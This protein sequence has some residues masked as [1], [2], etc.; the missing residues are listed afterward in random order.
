[1]PSQNSASVPIAQAIQCLRQE[2]SQ[3][4]A[5]GE[6]EDL[7]FKLGT[8]ELELQIEVSSEGSGQAGVQFG[9]VSLGAEGTHTRGTTHTIKLSLEPISPNEEDTIIKDQ[10][11]NLE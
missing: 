10:V 7:R 2:L 1:M 4:I 5:S 6:N 8:V 9:V 11:T 3:A